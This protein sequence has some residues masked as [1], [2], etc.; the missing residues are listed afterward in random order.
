[1]EHDAIRDLETLEH[2][3][4]VLH[5][6]LELGGR[7]GRCGHLHQLDLVELVLADH[8]LHVLAVG[9]G[10]APVARRERGVAPRQRGLGQHLTRMQRRQ[11]DLR[12]RDEI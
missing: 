1:V 7:L 9:A 4:G 12:G 11:R 3:F 5:H 10:L 8:P 2:F 6:R